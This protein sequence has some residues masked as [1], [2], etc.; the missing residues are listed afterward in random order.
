MEN[1]PR[2][3]RKAGCISPAEV[4]KRAVATLLSRRGQDQ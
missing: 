1:P 2:A 3:G 4:T